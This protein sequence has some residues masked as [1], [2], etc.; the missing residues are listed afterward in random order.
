MMRQV[1][2]FF[3]SISSG[4]GSQHRDPPAAAQPPITPLILSDD[5]PA[6]YELADPACQTQ[7]ATVSLT[8]ARI[9]SWRGQEIQRRMVDLNQVVSKSSLISPSIRETTF[10]DQYQRSCDFNRGQGDSCPDEKGQEVSW[11]L[12]RPSRPLRVCQDN[13]EFPRLSYE[14]VSLA[15]LV[16]IETASQAYR[17][18]D[19][20]A[21]PLRPIQLAVLPSFV[22]LYRNFPQGSENITLKTW[23]THNM[24]Y[25]PSIEMIAV[26]PEPSSLQSSLK[27]YF[28]E[29]EFVLAHEFGHHIELSRQ[30]KAAAR[31]DL[32]LG[33]TWDPMQHRYLSVSGGR[34]VAS[35]VMGSYS[36]ALADLFAFYAVGGDD[37][38]LVGLP[39][40]GLNRNPGN[41]SFGNG[42][43][44]VLTED[45]LELLLGLRDE[46]PTSCREPR[47]GDVHTVGA[48]F[49]SL[50]N[51]VFATLT[52]LKPEGEVGSI[53]DITQ[54]YK[55][56][57][58]WQDALLKRSHALG[59]S[60][61]A[62]ELLALLPSALEDTVNGYVVSLGLNSNEDDRVRSQLCAT[63]AER[64]PVIEQKPFGC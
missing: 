17:T 58:R 13:Q 38:S 64:V 35:Q 34:S 7:T 57:L 19:A 15:A 62:Q 39:C 44:K 3:L 51:Q 25:F 54:R 23:I 59:S 21:S 27:G 55:L 22:D 28:W 29:S 33:L 61:T 48:I 42:D 32:T 56:V 11:S 37:R 5:P 26:F 9:H 46:D 36:E 41:D 14:H 49:A 47:Y 24:A 50:L 52:A 53:A 60:A 12:M 40:L 10:N 4:C 1:L 63:V 2:Y 30:T 43:T 20:G 6:T 45:R 16:G 8:Q 31:F 18:A